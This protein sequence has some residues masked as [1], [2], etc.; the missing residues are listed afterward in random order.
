MEQQLGASA[1]IVQYKGVDLIYN[2]LSGLKGSQLTERLR[3]NG[4]AMAPRTKSR[5]DNVILNIFTDTLLDENGANYMR[6]L[7]KNMDGFFVACAIVGMSGIQKYLVEITETLNNTKLRSKF[8]DHETEAMDWMVEEY[9]K[10]T[11]RKR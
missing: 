5:S 2:D 1:K 11:N 10:L 7:H 4:R 3:E 6:K 9:K 8:F